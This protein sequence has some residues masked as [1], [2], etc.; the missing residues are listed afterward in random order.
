MRKLLFV[1]VTACAVAVAGIA[2]AQDSN[3]VVTLT[4]SA[5]KG[6]TP[7][8]PIPVAPKW[9]VDIAG[10]T[11]G[12]RS[13]SP[14][15]HD[16][17]WTGIQENGKFFPTCTAA[18]IDA[19]QSNA[20]CPKASVVAKGSLTAFLGPEGQRQYNTPCQKDI[21]I[22]NGG[23]GKAS[24]F[25]SGDPAACA[26]VGYLPPVPIVWKKKGH[27][28]TQ[29]FKFPENIVH[30]LPGVEGAFTHI[31]YTFVK[32]VTKVHGKKVGY[33]MSYGCG[34]AKR[35]SFA[36]TFISAA[37]KFTKTVDAGAC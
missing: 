31:Q 1:L 35:R 36:F 19:A 22:Y 23:A 5:P 18:K 2:Y 6:G 34:K 15:E 17:K 29:I 13:T 14:L 26:G 25:A 30:P 37:D 4:S 10:A 20:S 16:W 12:N 11:S 7:S 21:T 27:T 33:L 28:S 24:L 8:K 32:R 3:D 9:A